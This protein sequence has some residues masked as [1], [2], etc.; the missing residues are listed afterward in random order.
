VTVHEVDVDDDGEPLEPG[1][2]RTVYEYDAD[3]LRAAYEAR[4]GPLP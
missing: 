1:H 3:A 4:L 2:T